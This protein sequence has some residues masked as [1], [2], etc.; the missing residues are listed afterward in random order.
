MGI[1]LAP[2]QGLAGHVVLTGQPA[3]VADYVADTRIT[4]ELDAVVRQEGLQTHVGVPISSR[5]RAIGCLAVAFRRIR[6]VNDDEVH[7]LSRMANQ[8]AIAIENARLYDRVQSLAILEERD[9][10]GREM[11]DSLG[12]S[13]GLLNLKVKLVED[14]VAGGR[15][16]EAQEEL[17]QVR[18]TIREAYDEVRHAILGLRIPGAR[19]DLEVALRV[20]VARFREQA[21]LPVAYEVRGPTPAVPALAAVQIT[22]VVQE[23]LTN[24]RKHAEAGTV[25]VT[26]GVE[27][28]RLVVR[29]IDDGRGF[30]VEAVQATAGARFGLETMRERAESIGGTLAITSAPGRGTTVALWVPVPEAQPA[31]PV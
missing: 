14:L 26:L 1:E 6:P 19:E 18:Q 12:Q 30:D 4:H 25:R 8:A 15:T 9:R 11:H 17:T 3:V 24:V 21:K 2:G 29:V 22:R 7:L 20:Q 16:Q 28:G 31:R 27:E 10:L 23:A 13:L 5:G